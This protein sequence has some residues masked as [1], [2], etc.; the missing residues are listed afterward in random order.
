MSRNLGSTD[1]K[2]LHR[3]WRRRAPGKVALLLDSVG[4]PVNLGS[5]LRTAA[6][7]RVD[8]IWLC[9]Q[10]PAP[11]SSAAG[12]TAMGSERFLTFHRVDESAAAVAAAK[13]AG[14]RLVGIELAD[15]AAPIHEVDL[16]PAVCLALGH[17]DRGL[18]KAVLD[19]ADA[20]AFIPQ[21][22]RI[23]SLNVAVAA[24]IA[25][26]EARRQAWPPTTLADDPA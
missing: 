16:G 18:T 6:A 12:K 3:D 1:L 19:G 9:G 13:A 15:G 25:L 21:L 24:S 20:L 23:G 8:D 17:E 10:T 4:T 5:I 7:M 14:Y 26:Y 11:D 2:R 22:G